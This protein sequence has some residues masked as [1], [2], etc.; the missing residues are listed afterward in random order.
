M[1]RGRVLFSQI[2]PMQFVIENS[3]L[4][5][6]DEDVMIDVMAGW[7]TDGGSIP[8]IFWNIFPPVGSKTFNGFVIH[9]ALWLMREEYKGMYTMEETNR[10]MEQIHKESGVSWWRRKFIQLGVSKWT[11]FAWKKWNNPSEEV[12]N[13]HKHIL[14]IKWSNR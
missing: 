14:T 10:I 1:I 13:W 9:D 6:A 7:Y 4:T 3:S 11:Y 8:K 2:A 12:L 5:Y